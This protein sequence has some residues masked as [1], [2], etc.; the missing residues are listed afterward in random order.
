MYQLY[1]FKPDQKI[2]TFELANQS[3]NKFKHVYPESAT[4][5]FLWNVPV[6]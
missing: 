3:A 5:H 2:D 4:K 1:T 6:L